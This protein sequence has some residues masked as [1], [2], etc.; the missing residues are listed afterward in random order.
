MEE[1]TY[2]EYEEIK[3]LYENPHYV[4]LACAGS[5]QEVA[6]NAFGSTYYDVYE[7]VNRDTGHTEARCVQLPEALHVAAQ[8]NLALTERSWEWIEAKAAGAAVN[9]DGTPLE[10]P[11]EIH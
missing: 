5:E 7:V 2:E 11:T 9:P 3:V 4:V 8:L 6:V 10:E 1:L